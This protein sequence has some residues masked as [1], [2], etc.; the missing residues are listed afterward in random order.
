MGPGKE[1]RGVVVRRGVV[2]LADDDPWSLFVVFDD[3]EAVLRHR[4]DVRGGVKEQRGAP[5]CTAVEF[6]RAEIRK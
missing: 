4:T 6:G 3:G 2:L 5:A 1:R